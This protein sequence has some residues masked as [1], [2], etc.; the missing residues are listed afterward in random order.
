MININF[1]SRKTNKVLFTKPLEDLTTFYDYPLQIDY[2]NKTFTYP[3]NIKR[4]KNS[5]I[6]DTG[7]VQ[8]GYISIT[9]CKSHSL[10]EDAYKKLKDT[11]ITL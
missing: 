6:Y 7:A 8:R 1:T 4:K 5:I 9:L 2:K 11:V 3:F 10:N